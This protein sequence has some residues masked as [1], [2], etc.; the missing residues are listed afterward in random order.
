MIGLVLVIGIVVLSAYYLSN[1]KKLYGNDEGSIQK[2]I[3]SIEGYENRQIEILDIS[4]FH[5]S[6]VV[7]FLSDQRPGYI[8]FARNSKGNY[9]WKHIETAHDPV[10]LFMLNN[11]KEEVQ[12]WMV[13]THHDN[14]VAKM[15]VRINGELLEQTFVPNRADVT[16]IELPPSEDQSYTFRDYRFYD[17]RGTLLDE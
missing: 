15:Q 7:G 1:D 8:E 2:V 3:Q 5:D 4:D 11:P 13:V 14:Q 12:K 6:R 17:E 9:E 16:Y 10:G